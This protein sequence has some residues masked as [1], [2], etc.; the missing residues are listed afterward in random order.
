MAGSKA[1]LYAKPTRERTA[2]ITTITPISQK[3]LCMA[4]TSD[5]DVTAR[6]R[7]LEVKSSSGIR[8]NGN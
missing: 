5:S 3:I 4:L 8:G 1:G 2:M 7:R 6:Q